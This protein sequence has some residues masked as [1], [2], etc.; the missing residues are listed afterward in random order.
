MLVTLISLVVT[1]FAG[2]AG[3]QE[4]HSVE[5]L[6]TASKSTIIVRSFDLEKGKEDKGG[7]L[8][9]D[10]VVETDV[11]LGPQK[12]AAPSKEFSFASPLANKT[13]I[14][15][16]IVPKAMAVK[17]HGSLSASNQRT[18]ARQIGQL[19]RWGTEEVS[20]SQELRDN[21]ES[22]GIVDPVR[23]TIIANKEKDKQS[24]IIKGLKAAVAAIGLYKGVKDLGNDYA[25][26]S[27]LLTSAMMIESLARGGVNALCNTTSVAVSSLSGGF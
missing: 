14:T 2:V 20:I 19:Y 5:D 25:D 15:T 6:L 21:L 12:L 27:S 7:V 13:R 23:M 22:I 4:V 17:I 24:N 16:A 11:V 8:V 1:M 18:A 9:A 3:A 26:M 10:K